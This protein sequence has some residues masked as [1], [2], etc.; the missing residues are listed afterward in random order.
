MKEMELSMD[1]K[2]MSNYLMHLEE[3][4]S[5]ELFS[6]I[7]NFLLGLIFSTEPVLLNM[8]KKR[9]RRKERKER[10]KERRK[11]KFI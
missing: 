3:N 11:R 6:W 1:L 2:L 10:E 5:V 4:F 7:S 8:N 9:K